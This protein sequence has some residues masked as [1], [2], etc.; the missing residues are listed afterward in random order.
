MKIIA[1]VLLVAA[2]LSAQD[3]AL[4]ITAGASQG[5]LQLVEGGSVVLAIKDDN[6]ISGAG[7]KILID[8]NGKMLVT[9]AEFARILK[10]AFRVAASGSTIKQESHSPSSPNIANVKGDV[11]VTY[12]DSK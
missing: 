11:V 2:S 6:S 5:K 3:T 7:G 10:E 12:G 4:K 1:V 8:K 9:S